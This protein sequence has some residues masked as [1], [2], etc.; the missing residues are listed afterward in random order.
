[1]AIASALIHNPEVLLADWPTAALDSENA[2][3]TVKL[4][5][6]ITHKE[7]KTTVMVTHDQRLLPHCDRVY[8]IVDGVLTEVDLTPESDREW[9]HTIALQCPRGPRALPFSRNRVW[10]TKNR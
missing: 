3:D 7:Q 6:E 10:G 1:M 4:L 5:R 8:R 2:F 9:D